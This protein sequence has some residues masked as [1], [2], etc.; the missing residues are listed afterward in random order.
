MG[1][2]K[3]GLEI[4]RRL[5]GAKLRPLLEAS[6]LY[7]ASPSPDLD[8]VK[9]LG[10]LTRVANDFKCLVSDLDCPLGSKPG[11]KWSEYKSQWC[12]LE[13]SEK[14]VEAEETY[15]RATPKGQTFFENIFAGCEGDDRWEALVRF[16]D[17]DDQRRKAKAQSKRAKTKG[18]KQSL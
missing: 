12:N 1:K 2:A 11:T 14:L 9:R 16:R 4:I 8:E 5:A 3:E 18:N 6:G 10:N 17:E 13:H 15:L 7:L